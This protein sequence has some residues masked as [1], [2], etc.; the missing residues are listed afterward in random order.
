MLLK[1][2]Y[3]IL[4]NSAPEEEISKTGIASEKYRFKLKLN[5]A[6]PMYEGHFSGNPVVP[7]VCQIQIISELISLVK[8]FP[9]RMVYSD[10]V[11]FLTIMVPGSNRIIDVEIRLRTEP[12]GSISA[13]ASIYESDVIYMKFKGLYQKEEE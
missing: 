3:T 12:D 8:G 2:F 4:Y 1:D 6:H 13:N 10:S 5:P 7:G 9:L 11:K